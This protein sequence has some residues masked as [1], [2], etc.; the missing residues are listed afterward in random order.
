VR[1]RGGGQLNVAGGGGGGGYGPG[2]GAVAMGGW[3]C[4]AVEAGEGGKG[5]TCG[6][7]ATV[8]VSRVK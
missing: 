5:L 6:V 8:S 3:S 7:R 2:Q 1:W 4:V